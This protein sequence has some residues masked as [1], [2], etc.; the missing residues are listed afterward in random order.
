V[1]RVST[2]DNLL[3]EKILNDGQSSLTYSSAMAPVKVHQQQPPVQQFQQ[4]PLTFA[5]QPAV[6]TFTVPRQQQPL[7]SPPPGATQG[8]T[9]F[10]SQT[11]GPYGSTNSMLPFSSSSIPTQQSQ[12]ASPYFSLQQPP[13]S[14]G[15]AMPIQAQLGSQ[16][17]PGFT[18]QTPFTSG[19]Q[20]PF[21]SGNQTPF[22]SGNQTPFTSGN[23]TQF[24]SG[25]QTQFTS[26]TQSQTLPTYPTFGQISQPQVL[27]S[28][29]RSP[30]ASS[31][32]PQAYPQQTLVRT[33]QHP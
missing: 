30:I 8:W 32:L 10:G 16:Q 21:T 15:S 14:A 25:N 17:K 29:C 19:N 20:T 3:E 4:T 24:T 2:G 13:L 5:S 28:A 31:Q 11:S 26:G 9:T 18:A 27:M 33:Y 6:T 12:L 7:S 1:G 23:Q 22:T